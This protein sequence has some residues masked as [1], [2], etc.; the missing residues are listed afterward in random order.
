MYQG[1]QPPAG[2]ANGQFVTR[3]SFAPPTKPPTTPPSQRA[4]SQNPTQAFGAS[5][6]PGQQ[7]FA[8]QPFQPESFFSRAVSIPVAVCV[9]IIGLALLLIFPQ[10]PLI[11]LGFLPL[12]PLGAYF[13]WLGSLKPDFLP[14]HFH[15]LL[16]GA[17]VAVLIAGTVNSGLTF[18]VG[19]I[20]N[21]F[22]PLVLSAPIGE[23]IMKGLAVVYAIKVFR[24][25]D[26]PLDGLIAAGWAAAG[27][28]VIENVVFI[29][30]PF[31]VLDT[32][33]TSINPTQSAI[34]VALLRNMTFF[35]HTIASAPI[36]YALGKVI[37]DN[38]PLI[39]SWWGWLLAM[40]IHAS[41]NGALW[42]SAEQESS[43]VPSQTQTGL[44]FVGIVMMGFVVALIVYITMTITA[45][46]Q[47]VS[48]LNRGLGWLANYYRLP[49]DL[50][51]FF[52]NWHDIK[53][54]RS[55]Q[56]RASRRSVNEIATSLT[57]LGQIQEH[58]QRL[59]PQVHPDRANEVEV[60]QQLQ[61]A[62][63]RN[64]IQLPTTPL[65]GINAG[66]NGPSLEPKVDPIAISNGNL[67][68]TVEYH[69]SYI[70]NYEILPQVHSSD[71]H[72]KPGTQPISSPQPLPESPIR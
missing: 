5:P 27:F 62:I 18:F 72:A 55:L 61:I 24:S 34:Q 53:S 29:S 30:T 70:S 44:A 32:G 43:L 11:V 35:V 8:A 12:L 57:R 16:W 28:T 15:S 26:S 59:G 22:I 58:Y 10:A 33:V 36:G 4:P 19:D 67:A 60:A 21:E 52:S 49:L 14:Y 41:W 69:S 6:A 45:K 31:D 46:N 64:L 56:V 9:P 48:N 65:P 47:A 42:F 7:I 50:R 39:N 25:I 20:A 71:Q 1:E 13:L 40:G 38:K 3:P 68:P 54:L 17:A 63:G 66:W 2:P 37:S 23:E 51:A